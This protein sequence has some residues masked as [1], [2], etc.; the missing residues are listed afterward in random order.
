MAASLL[1]S[2]RARRINSQRMQDKQS[3]GPE[4]CLWGS[5]PPCAY[6]DLV[7]ENGF[8][9]IDWPVYLQCAVVPLWSGG[10]D[11]GPGHVSGGEMYI[12]LKIEGQVIA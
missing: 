2:S 11:E 10:T 5:I 4:N 1:R 8:G 7:C 6:V 3:P 9:E 12:L